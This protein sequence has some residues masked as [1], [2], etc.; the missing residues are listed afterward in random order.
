MSDTLCPL[1]VPTR[2]LCCGPCPGRGGAHR[3]V[4]Q[5][6]VSPQTTAEHEPRAG[7]GLQGQRPLPGLQ[8]ELGPARG[9][10][11]QQ[12]GPRGFPVPALRGLR[13]QESP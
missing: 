9:S 4:C 1:C 7:A 5:V 8:E 11:L 10:P 6:G 13:G 3:C 2:E 12:Q